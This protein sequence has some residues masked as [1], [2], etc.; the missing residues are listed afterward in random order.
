MFTVR[1]ALIS[2]M[3]YQE[4]TGWP[5]LKLLPDNTAAK[6]DENSL[7]RNWQWDFRH[8]TPSYKLQKDILR[9]S[10]KQTKDN[11]TGIALTVRPTSDNFDMTTTVLNRNKALKGLTIYGDANAAVGI[12][13]EG[14]SVKVWKVEKNERVIIKA[15]RVPVSAISLK[16]AMSPNKTCDFF[17]QTKKASW[18]ELASHIDAKFLPQWDRS[19]RLGLH[20]RGSEEDKAEFY[21]FKLHNK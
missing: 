2:Q 21:L 15:A 6:T 11:L 7:D 12:G 14:D 4:Y 13:V 8:A 19:P 18:V 10:G 16:I 5:L 1:E 3:I 20:Y 9:L 17:Y